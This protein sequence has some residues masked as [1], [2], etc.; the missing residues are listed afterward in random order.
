[1][2]KAYIKAIDYYLPQKILTNE[3][4]IRDFPEWSVD[5]IIEK[6]GINKRHIAAD[7]ETATDL[8]IE[9]ANKL[10][11]HGID[12]GD[13]DY[14]LFCTQS[15]DYFLPAS[16]CI[17]QNRLG[18]S[19]NIG[20]VDFNQGC[21]GFVYGLSLAKGLILG[22]IARNVLLLTA[23]TYT[24]KLHIRDKGNRTIFGDGAT[25]TLI[26]TEGFAEIGEFCLGTDGSGA[27]QLIIKTGAARNPEKSNKVEFDEGNNPVSPDHI[28]M[29]G[30]EIFSFTLGAVPDLVNRTLD[31]N[32][33]KK[34]DIDLF[35]F[36]QANKYMLDFLRKKLK[37]DENKFYLCLSE[38][39]NTVSS[40]IPIATCEA[41]KDGSM[42]KKM[43]VLLAGFGVGLSWA[44]V[45]LE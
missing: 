12:R 43:K 22:N 2:T 24:K 6:V 23:E 33:I 41:L 10:F 7:N 39:G 29:N 35:V 32:S 3:D 38:V 14:I 13:I 9:A 17:I 21:S 8:A 36:H 19:K 18:L 42:Q 11:D 20:A 1:M 16:A 40:T 5:K 27:E 26:S 30:S 45:C 34:E 37:I 25:A 44:G 31:K 15:P 4:L 28:Y